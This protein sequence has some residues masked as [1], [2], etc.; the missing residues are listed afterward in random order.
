MADANGTVLG[1]DFGTRRIGVAVG[2]AITGTASPVGVLPTRD[3]APD[4]DAIR[5]LVDEWH[6]GLLVVGLPLNMDGT[7]SDLSTRARSFGRKLGG[8]TGLPVAHVDERLTSFEARGQLMR[9]DN[10][11]GRP[12]LDALAAVLIVEDWLAGRQAPGNG[13]SP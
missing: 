2:N 13:G 5:A 6:P 11:R 4:W 12:A 9:S 3:G 7:E 8:R 10:K 1:F